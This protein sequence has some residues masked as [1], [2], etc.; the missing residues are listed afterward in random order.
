MKKAPW[1][2]SGLL[3][4]SGTARSQ[5]GDFE[6]DSTFRSIQSRKVFQMAAEPTLKGNFLKNFFIG[7]NYRLEWIQPVSAPVL[8][9]SK[10]FGS[11]EPE[12]EGGGKQT[13]NLKVIDGKGRE[14]ALRS[15]AKYPERGL[16]EIMQGTLAGKLYKDALSASYPYAALSAGTLAKA[17][18]IRYLPNTLVIIPDDAALGKYRDKYKNS[19]SFMELRSVPLKKDLDA[20]TDNTF[21]VNF[22]RHESN[23]VLLDQTTLLRARLLDNFMMDFDRHEDQWTWLKT[24]SAGFDYYIP[25]PKDRDQ[26]FFD[27]DGFL[28]QIATRLSSKLGVFQGLSAKARNIKTFNNSAF[29]FDR[30]FLTQPDI[31]MWNREI[32][33][34]LSAMTDPVIDDAMSRQPRE[35][36]R[37]QAPQIART[38]KDKRRFFK[39]D[40]LEYYRTLARIVDITGSNEQELF[41]LTKKNDNT[42]TVQVQ[43]MEDGAPA[44]TIYQRVFNAPETSEVRVYGLEGNDKFVVRGGESPIKL[45]IVGGP[46]EDEFVNEGSGGRVWVY[47]VSFE[48]NLFAGNGGFKKKISDDPMNNEYRQRGKIFPSKSFNIALELTGEGGLFL[49]PTLRIINPG[50]RKDPYASRHYFYVAKALT[51]PAWHLGWDADYV[52]VAKNT[53]LLFRSDVRLP[54]VQSYFF[55]YGNNT[56]FTKERSYYL[57]QYQKADVSLMLDRSISNWLHLQAGPLAQYFK[58]LPSWNEGKYVSS[59]YPQASAK[60]HLYDGLWYVGGGL[61]LEADTKNDLLFPTQGIH[62]YAYANSWQGI[63]HSAQNWQQIGGQFSFFTDFIARHKIVLASGF[64][65]DHNLG[66]FE[67]PQAQYLGFKQNLRGYRFQRYAGRTR[68]YNNTELRANFGTMNFFLF[69]GMAGI[70]AFHDVGRVWAD[71]ENADEWHSGYGGGVWVAPF[72]KVVVTGIL[73]YSKEENN[74]LQASF[75]FRF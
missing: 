37:Y 57:A 43:R 31:A 24:D 41:T 20:N 51:S 12:E 10:D 70:L 65:V 68:A 58:L 35:V 47:D 49:G 36:M 29:D 33:R 30:A 8:D 1:I 54:L 67:F 50:F 39:D 15:V 72:N 19:L 60:A 64:G 18:G 2:I 3:A 14:W 73:S 9:F 46:G 23:K 26:A 66:E 27:I 55:G 34:F 71:G 32:D 42:L 25:I 28:P 56:S 59:L 52:D 4:L 16:P 44:E 17:V 40:M 7:K 5:V 61:R 74:W 6:L 11:L 38:L 53:D 75:G 13:R 69:K 45:R 21:K 22:K 48:E 63:S 62:S